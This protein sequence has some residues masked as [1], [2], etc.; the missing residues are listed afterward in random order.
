MFVY[1]E[2]KQHIIRAYIQLDITRDDIRGNVLCS[3]MYLLQVK[4]LY[5]SV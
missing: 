2:E 4:W 5:R 3:F 1:L